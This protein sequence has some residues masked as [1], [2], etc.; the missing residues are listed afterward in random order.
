MPMVKKLV[1]SLMLF[2]LV[3]NLFLAGCQFQRN[4][5]TGRLEWR[6]EPE[7]VA[8][9]EAGLEG[10]IGILDILAPLLGP[11]GGIVTGTAAT[12]LA[13]VKKYKPTIT[14]YKSKA[15]MSHAVATVSV[16]AIEL[17]KERHPDVWNEVEDKVR[18]FI[19]DNDLPTVEIKNAIRGL[20]GLPSKTD[21]RKL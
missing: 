1:W 19:V 18:K 8:N 16:D 10:G 3:C 15:E 13:L 4:A 5:E 9:V 7:V 6:V 11:V 17:I 20:R 14:T 12:A 21:I 2:L